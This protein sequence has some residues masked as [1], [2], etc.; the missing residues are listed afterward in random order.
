MAWE[1]ELPHAF[2]AMNECEVGRVELAGKLKPG[3]F[4]HKPDGRYFRLFPS[5][6]AALQAALDTKTTQATQ[7]ATKPST[8]FVLTIAFTEKQWLQL[9]LAS[10]PGPSLSW[11]TGRKDWMVFG[12]LDFGG[13]DL[14]WAKIMLGPVGL[15]S[16][17]E[18]SLRSCN[19]K[20]F[21]ACAG[22]QADD[23]PVWAPRKRS[24]ASHYCA[25]C[26][27]EFILG[28]CLK[29]EGAPDARGEGKP[30]EP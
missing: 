28:K 20:Q 7:A 10:E 5:E 15:R 24:Q 21:G 1:G 22:C 16:W 30:D 9:F 19:Y 23:I 11:G 18:K 14:S 12:E 25:L 4:D 8:W 2:I 3:C 17:A 6:A 29:P 27:H 13:L 26:W